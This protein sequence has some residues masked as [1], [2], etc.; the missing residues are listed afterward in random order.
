MP[1]F[2]RGHHLSAAFQDVMQWLLACDAFNYTSLM[3]IN[4]APEE[5]RC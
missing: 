4:G 1:S 3:S 2:P 5:A